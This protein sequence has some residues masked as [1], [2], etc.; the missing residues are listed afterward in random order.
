MKTDIND[1]LSEITELR[2]RYVTAGN[3]GGARVAQQA[4]TLSELFGKYDFTPAEFYGHLQERLA[5]FA[6][7]YQSYETEEKAASPVVLE[8]INAYKG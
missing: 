2:D 8:V 7:I 4:L 1:F 5:G 6:K 3:K